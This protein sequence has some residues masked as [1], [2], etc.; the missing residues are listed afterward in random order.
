M[1]SYPAGTAGR[2]TSLGKILV[3]GS[4][5]TKEDNLTE[6]EVERV[7]A[8]IRASAELLEG[9]EFGGPVVETLRQVQERWDGK[10]QPEGR[11]GE[12][13]LVTAR[14]VA[15][16]NAL[17]ALISPR[18]HRPALDIDRVLAALLEQSGGAYDRGV[19]A[20]LVNH[21]DNRAGRAAWAGETQSA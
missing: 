9:I 13:I 1:D 11:A 6:D 21:M 5:L 2:L 14:I 20:A 8:S 4:G 12:A 16:A 17:V 3:S 15:V 10:G 7:R 18:A 19:V